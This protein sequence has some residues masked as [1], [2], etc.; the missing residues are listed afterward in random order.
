M[1]NSSTVNGTWLDLETRDMSDQE[2]SDAVAVA[3]QIR[4]TRNAGAA[5]ERQMNVATGG[6]AARWAE[7]NSPEAG[8][9]ELIG[10]YVSAGLSSDQI[11]QRLRELRSGAGQ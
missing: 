5:Y 2:F 9:R 1:R 4:R 11:A 7:R 6:L 8:T 3:V 10:A